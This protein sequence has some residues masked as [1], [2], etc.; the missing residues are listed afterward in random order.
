[1]T[2]PD[3]PA[4]SLIRTRTLSAE[5]RAAVLEIAAAAHAV[6]G[7]DPLSD[8]ARVELSGTTVEHLLSMDE[9]FLIGYA[10]LA[11]PPAGVEM[12]VAPDARREGVATGLLMIARASRA[13]AIGAAAETSIW[14]H[15]NL[16]EAAAMAEATGMTK[17]RELWQMRL[18][19]TAASTGST[20]LPSGV[21]LRPFIPGADEAAWLELNAA[22]FAHHPEQGAWTPSDLA[23]RED[24]PWFDPAGLLIAE[25]DG[26]V[27]ATAWTKIHPEGTLAAETVG[28]LYVLAVHPD[29]QRIGLGAAL[30]RAAINH[31]SAA[32]ITVAALWTEADNIAAVHT[33]EAAGFETFSTD[34][35]YVSPPLFTQRPPASA[36]MSA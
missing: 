7:V 11:E 17:R 26:R 14:A 8:Q 10:Q 23:A 36:T 22:A 18:D 19:L 6:D 27:I 13:G 30:L 24:E 29:A 9:Q 25:R 16:P 21:T 3:Q 28:E 15:G 20:P 33:Y 4:P 34:V 1:M 31:I 5:Q 12:F 2:I 32:G 35:M